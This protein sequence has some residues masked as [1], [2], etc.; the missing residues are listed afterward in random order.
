MTIDGSNAGSTDR[1][2]TIKNTSTAGST[3][4]VWVASLGIGAGATND[5]IKNCVI[6]AGST[7]VAATFGLY[8]AGATIS[9]SGGVTIT[10]T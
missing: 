9:S 1:S 6:T 3:A 8:A 2:L 5:T 4:V 10:T 7:T